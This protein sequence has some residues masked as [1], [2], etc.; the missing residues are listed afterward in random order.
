VSTLGR[1]KAPLLAAAAAVLFAVP[2]TAGAAAPSLP[3]ILPGD[4]TAASVPAARST[5]IVGARP[6]AAARQLAARF[7]ARHVGLRGTG[8]YVLSR[9]RARGFAGAL[10]ERG[11]LVYAQPNSLVRPLSVPNDPLSTTPYNWRALVAD[12]ALTPPVVTA[13]SPL[14]AL[15]DA[16]LDKTHP[17][18]LGG[19]TTTISKFPV[20]IAHGTAT[21]S[22]AAAPVNGRGFVGVWPGARALNVPLPS[23]ITC[24]ASGNQIAAAIDAGASVINMSYGS[25]AL[26]TPEYVAIQFA[27]ARGIV[28]VAAAG[29]EF[30]QGNPTEFP[31]SLPHVLTVASVG[32]DLKSSYFSNANAA[33]DLSAPG[34]QIMTAVPP[35]LDEDATKDGYEVQN[36]TSFSAPMVAA[37]AAWVRAAR[38][39]LTEDQIAQ[40]IRL[41]ARDLETPGWDPN[42]G[43]GLLSV[44]NALTFSPPPPDPAEPNDDIVWVD[45]RAFGKPDRLF[46][47]GKG[48][49][50]LAGTLDVFEDPADVY[51]IKLRGHS[52]RTILA[53]PAGKDDIALYVYAK[54]VKRLSAKPLKKSTHRKRGRNEKVVLRNRDRK[55]HVYYVALRDQPGSNDLDAVYSL[56]V[57]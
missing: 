55:P 25:Q 23:T 44:G 43:F 14:I 16:Q 47:N 42:T 15:V 5:W 48:K 49:K 24:A 52:R 39:T 21:A 18:F 37:A 54:K 13:S 20:T 46:Y 11:L 9:A 35:A 56:R 57:G 7:G 40:A 51:R 8:G 32:P 4:A 1:M 36:G 34:E 17:E 27:V 30:D 31:A 33:I 26:C 28:P 22:V 38:P 6:G 50:R 45:G 3:M 53:N 12:P 10:R 19:H 29:N 2:A 41:S